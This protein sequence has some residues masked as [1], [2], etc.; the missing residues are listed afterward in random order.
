MNLKSLGLMIIAAL[1]FAACEKE[2]GTTTVNAAKEVAGSYSG[3]SLA[4]FQYSPQPMVTDGE[5]VMLKENSDGTVSVSYT[6][7]KWGEFTVPAA[8]ASGSDGIYVVTGD[9]TTVMGMSAETKKEYQCSLNGTVNKKDNKSGFVFSVPAVMGGL[10]IEFYTGEIPAA[11]ALAGTYKGSLK[12]EVGG[13]EVGN[14]DDSQFTIEN[15]DGKMSLTLKGF[16]FGGMQLEDIKVSDVAAQKENESYKISSV[17]D[18][19]SGSVKVTGKLDGTVGKD[20]KAAVVFTMK[21]GAMP[22]DIT[23]SFTGNR[24]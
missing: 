4:K 1:M 22:M 8:K 16:G 17:I 7:S 23:A 13:K 15:N 2:E 21:P 5:T 20:G 18:T 24:Q 10:N 12:L 11:Y 9:G 14:V 3:Y 19:T 6:S